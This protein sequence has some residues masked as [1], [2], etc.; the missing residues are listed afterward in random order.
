VGY[1]YTEY[2]GYELSNLLKMADASMYGEKQE[3][4]KVN[5]NYRTNL[6]V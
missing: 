6:S 3:H 4:Y 5:K 1:S 2:H